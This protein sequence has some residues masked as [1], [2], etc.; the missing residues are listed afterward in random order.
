MLCAGHTSREYHHVFRRS[1]PFNLICKIFPDHI[2]NDG[3]PV[4]TGHERLRDLLCRKC[5]CAGLE[6]C[7]PEDVKSDECL[8]FLEPVGK[9]YVDS[10]HMDDYFL[11]TV[12]SILLGMEV[13]IS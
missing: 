12:L 2:G 6:A 9:K 1:S 10:F 7:P 8:G 3:H 5:D 4:G 13:I 11:I